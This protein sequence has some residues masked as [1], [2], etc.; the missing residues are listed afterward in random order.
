MKIAIIALARKVL[1]ILYHLLVHRE[2]Y[3]EDGSSMPRHTR[4]S[5]SAIPNELTLDKMI[6]VLMRAGYVIEK[7]AQ[8]K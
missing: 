4:L 1:F 7:I 8:E 5:H 2:D 3:Q 6:E